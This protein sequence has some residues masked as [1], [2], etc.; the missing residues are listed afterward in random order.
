MRLN[1]QEG[2]TVKQGE[3]LV[4]LFD[5]D[6]QA[7]LRKLQVQL[8]IANKNEERLRDLLAINGISQQEY[9]LS[10]LN[11]EN[12]KADIESTRIA[13]SKP[14]FVHRMKAS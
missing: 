3:L 1:V 6:L 10:K 12:L 14:K 9:D 8:E 4:K 7:T 2:T 11:V 5:Q 13:I